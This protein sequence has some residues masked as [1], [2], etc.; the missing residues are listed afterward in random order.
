MLPSRFSGAIR[1]LVLEPRIR[2]ALL[3]DEKLRLA[4]LT[5]SVIRNVSDPRIYKTFRSR[6]TTPLPKSLQSAP[7]GAGLSPTLFSPPPPTETTFP[8]GLSH[9]IALPSNAVTGA[10]EAIRSP[11]LDSKSLKKAFRTRVADKLAN[12]SLHKKSINTYK[13]AWAIFSR[14]ALSIQS[15][16][17]LRLDD[18]LTPLDNEV[19]LMWVVTLID[20]KVTAGGIASKI[21]A[22]KWTCDIHAKPHGLDANSVSRMLGAAHRGNTCAPEK[23]KPVVPDDLKA[24]FTVCTS[25]SVSLALACQN[26]GYYA[27]MLYWVSEDWGMSFH[28]QRSSTI[29][30]NP[31]HYLLSRS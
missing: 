11:P 14:F 8:Q 25:P 17:S 9:V 16:D 27:D 5:G 21:S 1:A 6:L 19:V 2:L 22:L 3:N 18:P 12:E 4:R 13:S 20:A 23:A 29:L 7:Q 10:K 24:L 15:M 31:P 30:T 28:P 26:T